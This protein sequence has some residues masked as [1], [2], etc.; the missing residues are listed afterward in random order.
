MQKNYK[1]LVLVIIVPFFSLCFASCCLAAGTTAANFLKIDVSTRS[2]AM[3]GAF[4]ALAN[5]AT[6]IY[7]NPAGLA[8]LN[9]KEIYLMHNSWFQGINQEYLSLAMPTAKGVWGISLN[10]LSISDIERR[11][12]ATEEPE[13]TFSS[14]DGAL[15]L[16]LSRKLS[17]NFL[18]GVNL[19]GI[20]EQIDENQAFAFA[21]D[22]GLLYLLPRVNFAL[23]VKNIGTR[24]KFKQKEC[25][26]PL[27]YQAGLALQL[28]QN[29]TL[30]LQAIK[31]QDED[32]YYSGGI[33][34]WIFDSLALRAGYTSNI[35][36]AELGEFSSLQEGLSAGL[37]IR[38]GDINLDYAF[39]PYG[40]LGDTH[41]VSLGMRL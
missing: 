40:D 18:V 22:L 27:T 7:H 14:F 35:T 17:E 21:A 13:G 20:V 41:R 34:I 12:S 23:T 2:A 39:V 15:T 28:F 11:S 24:I 5:D 36:Q 3:G 25:S 6:A 33:E 37:G 38:I 32:I 31:E 30:T 16:S 26:L 10:Y 1:G 9:G 29:T 19:K 4:C 8:Q